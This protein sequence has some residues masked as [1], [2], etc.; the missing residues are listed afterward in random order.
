VPV[1]GPITPANAKWYSPAATDTTH[2]PLRAR[3]LLRSIGLR[4]ANEDGDFEDASG[5]PARFTILTQAGQVALERGASVLRD[6]L[7]KIGLTVDVVPLEIG[8]VVERFQ[9]ATGY[10]AVFFR[11][12]TSDTD[13][14]INPDF[15]LSSGSAH[16]WNVLLPPDARRTEP[17]SWER[18]I[19]DLM[20]QQMA[21]SDEAE[22]K[23]LFDQVQ[24]IFAEHRPILC[25]AAPKVVVAASRRVTNLSPAVS[26]PQL[27][28]SVD[29]LAVRH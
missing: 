8:S 11:L 6:E 29:T 19:D 3:E 20:A 23:R 7:H 25:F 13:P 22:R 28:W 21:A 18:R 15:W 14:A 17:M 9:A 5:A 1:S 4:D 2:N 12:T 27:L 16:V 26:F 10:D 24:A